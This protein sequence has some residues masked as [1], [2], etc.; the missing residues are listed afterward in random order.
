MNEQQPA[1]TTCCLAWT[2]RLVLTSS[3]AAFASHT[4]VNLGS[5]PRPGLQPGSA[6]PGFSAGQGLGVCICDNTPWELGWCE[7]TAGRRGDPSQQPESR[8]ECEEL[9]ELVH[10]LIGSLHG[11]VSGAQLHNG[12][13]PLW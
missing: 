10:L 4:A 13:T 7:A 6:H 2:L 3:V 1:G 12:W 5:F 11:S 8:S 9:T